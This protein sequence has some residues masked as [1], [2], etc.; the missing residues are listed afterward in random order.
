MASDTKLTVS[1]ILNDASF[2]KQLT[3]VNKELKLIQSVFKNASAGTTNF[4]TTLTGV[5]TKLKSL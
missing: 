1:L 5:Q 2:T 4:G 3:A